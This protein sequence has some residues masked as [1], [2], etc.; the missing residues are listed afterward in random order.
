[1]IQKYAWPLA[2]LALALAL[3]ARLY[4]DVRTEVREKARFTDCALGP[5]YENPG[6]SV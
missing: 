3:A 2:T 4:H 6:I 1:M 5:W